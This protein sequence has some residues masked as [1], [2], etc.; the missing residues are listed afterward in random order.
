MTR[1]SSI[2]LVTEVPEVAEVLV[3]KIRRSLG[4][5]CSS[6]VMAPV[7]G[8]VLVV[9]VAESAAGALWLGPKPLKL[10]QVLSDIQRA[11]EAPKQAVL[12]GGLALDVKTKE[13]SYAG[14]KAA[15]TDK[16]TALLQCLALGAGEPVAREAMLRQVW[17][18]ESAL[19]THTL[20]THIYRLRNKLREL[21]A[22]EEWITARDGGYALNQV[23]GHDGE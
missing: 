20:E 15:L 13:L 23:D 2:F 16:E 14:R 19:D 7:E 11:M 17:G 10:E 4:V 8:D 12:A 9:S 3:D 22:P 1:F 5:P 21:G 6:G 18:Y